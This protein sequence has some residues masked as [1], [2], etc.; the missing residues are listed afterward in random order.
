[1]RRWAVTR[2][3]VLLIIGVTLLLGGVPLAVRADGLGAGDPG[4]GHIYRATGLGL[5]AA[6]V[7]ALWLATWRGPP[8]T[9]SGTA[10]RIW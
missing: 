7:P 5:A 10:R 9:G 4:L 1:M 6:G 3:D 8:T 2:L